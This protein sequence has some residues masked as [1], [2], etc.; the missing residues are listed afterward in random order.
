MNELNH[1]EEDYEFKEDD[2]PVESYTHPTQENLK[3]MGD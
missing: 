2:D 1:L 3:Y